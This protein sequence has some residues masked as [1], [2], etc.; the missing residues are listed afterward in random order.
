MALQSRHDALLRRAYELGFGT[1]DLR[2]FADEAGRIVRDAREGTKGSG[3]YKLHG[4]ER[5]AITSVDGSSSMA[6]TLVTEN[7]GGMQKSTGCVS[8]DM[9][10][11]KV[12]A[13]EVGSL[14]KGLNVDVDVTFDV[15]FET[16]L[17][18]M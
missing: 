3:N 4:G 10:V 11:V 13:V 18:W 6:A 5:D 17:R 14:E 12:V 2:A 16:D 9:P 7:G 15:D 1:Q 8:A